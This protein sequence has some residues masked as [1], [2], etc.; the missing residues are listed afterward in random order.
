M[1]KI[2]KCSFFYTAVSKGDTIS[3][4]GSHVE[5]LWPPKEI[6]DSVLK[7]IKKAIDDFNEAKQE[8]KILNEIY[9]QITQREL[10]EKYFSE[11]REQKVE[12]DLED[13]NNLTIDGFEPRNIPEKTKRANK[14]IK[15]A[16]NHLSIAFRYNNQILFLGDLESSELRQISNHLSEKNLTDYLIIITPHHGTHWHNSLNQLSSIYAISSVGSNLFTKIK[17]EFKRRSH[18]CLYTYTNGDIEIPHPILRPLRYWKGRY[19]RLYI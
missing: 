11:K 18:I 13:L 7:V 6:D 8:D 12:N 15:K 10:G 14:S 9:N 4:S 1:S 16:A 19:W 17:T 3:L 5:I 2:N